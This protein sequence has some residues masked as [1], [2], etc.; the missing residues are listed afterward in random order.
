[1]ISRLVRLKRNLR[2]RFSRTRLAARLLGRE[3]AVHR[4]DEPGLI[5][6]QI[7][8][9]S[10]KQCEA[11][12]EAGRMP[13]LA[14]MLKCG[15]YDLTSFYSGLPSTTPAVQGEV[16]F[17]IR[18]AVPAFQYL[19]RQSGKTYVMYENECA[20][21]IGAKL[22]AQGQPLL[23][24]GRSYANIYAAG[25]NEA[26]LCAETLDL[27][28]FRE[29]AR[30]SKLAIVFALYFFTLVRIAGL[31]ALE[32]FIALGDFVRGLAGRQDWHAEFR[33]IPSRVGVSIVMREWLRIIVKLSIAEG[34]P[35]IYA[36]FL[37]YDEQAHRRGPG[38]RFAHWGLKGIDD[39]MGDVFRTAHTSDARAYEV[40]VFA[41]HGQE[42]TKIYETEQGV[43]VQTAVKRAFTS[44]PLAERTVRTLDG[45]GGRGRERDQRARLFLRTRRGRIAPPQVTREQLVE[46]IIV[47]AMG[48]LGHI[49]LP[50][51]LT[52]KEQAEYARRL[53]QEEKIPLIVYRDQTGAVQARNARGAWRLPVDGVAVFGPRHPFL[54]EA[55]SDLIRLAE[56][57]DSGDLIL[58]G[59]HSEQTPM[60]FVQENGAHGS[61]GVDETRSFILVPHAVSIRR[62]TRAEGETYSRGEDLHRAAWEFVHPERPLE[63]ANSFAGSSDRIDVRAST[64]AEPSA[65]GVEDNSHRPLRVMTYNIHSCIGLDGRVSPKRIAQVIRSSQAEVIALQ[66]V[67]ANRPRSHRHDQ[68]RVIAE[69]LAMSHHYYAVSDWEGERYGLAIISCFPLEHVQ[70]GHLTPPGPGRRSEARGALWVEIQ[71][72]VGPVHVVN[73]HFGLRREERLRQTAMLLGVDWIGG[74][75]PSEPVILCGDMNAGPK[76][77]VC[78]ALGQKLFDAQTGI[79]D[80][81]PRA[82]FIS[83]LPVRRLDHIF[84]STHFEVRGVSVPRS[85]TAAIASDHL[86]VCADLWLASDTALRQRLV[87]SDHVQQPPYS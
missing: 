65:N 11:A 10:R 70:S 76:S 47:T 6:L 64:R 57:P 24:G 40:I 23:A 84:I 86:P 12:L 63:S 39:V 38:S 54:A 43:D 59:W 69:Q 36:N 13:F 27:Q 75:P 8:G 14:R 21:E 82:T 87:A 79:K 81:R 66:E 77:P 37:G 80:F 32:F 17:G 56:H 16:M 51:T 50:M 68:A 7:D 18:T 4:G 15:H 44:G 35:I 46:E 42:R 41:D 49:Y 2:R 74:V 5:I 55:V 30:P 19:N 31:A 3:V 53:V 9:L 25:A 67:D 48:P 1:M 28:S 83:T 71:T 26:R 45:P 60:T 34:A 33:C 85:P 52:D 29:M 20:K 72:P 78:R 61:I 22:A 58:S 73:T 62:R